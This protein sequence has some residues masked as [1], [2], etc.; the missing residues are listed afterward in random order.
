MSGFGEHPDSALDWTGAL[1]R[2]HEMFDGDR[3]TRRFTR[4][5]VNLVTPNRLGLA[6]TPDGEPVEISTGMM[7]HFGERPRRESRVFGVTFN[8]E[9]D[10]RSRLCCS[11]DEARRVVNGD[12]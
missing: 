4:S 1:R 7:P 5:G 2:F 12:E 11:L 3:P 9:H 6:A 8:V 10:G